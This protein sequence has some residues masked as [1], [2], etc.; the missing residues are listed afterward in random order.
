MACGDRYKKLAVTSSGYTFENSFGHFA[1]SKDYEEWVALAKRLENMATQRFRRLAR[2]ECAKVGGINCALQGLP[3][4]IAP[5][6]AKLVR[7]NALEPLKSSL[8]DQIENLPS[9]WVQ[10]NL[11]EGVQEAQAA[12]ASAL[13]LMEESDSALEFYGEKPL[14]VPDITPSSAGGTPW[15]VWGL[16][17]VGTVVVV[18]S[19]G[20]GLYA[21]HQVRQAPPTQKTQIGKGRSGPDD[22]GAR[23]AESALARSRGAA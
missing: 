6:D 4:G 20:Y 3:Y 17:G 11:S 1:W 14:V 5:F 9:S 19:V 16:V 18:G 13:C 2:V 15:W 8:R 22:L 10:F 12:V 7:T 23:L 21:K